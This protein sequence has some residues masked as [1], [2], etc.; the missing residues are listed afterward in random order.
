MRIKVGVSEGCI[1]GLGLGGLV[2]VENRADFLYW[3]GFLF[4]GWFRDRVI[5]MMVEVQIFT[6]FLHDLCLHSRNTNKIDVT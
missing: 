4:V 2:A 3:V 1:E 5:R 6:C